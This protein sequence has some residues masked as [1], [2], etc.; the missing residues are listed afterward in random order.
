M[1]IHTE[2]RPRS[3]DTPTK[4]PRSAWFGVLRR[5]FSEFNEDAMTDWAAALT[6]YGILSVFPALIALVSILG[7]I[8]T[9][10]TKPLLDNLGSFAPGPAHQILKNAL[11][12]LTQSRGGAGIL[13]VV[14]L[15]GALWAASGYIGAF[16][17]A[18]NRIWDVEEG[19]PIWR[20]LPLRLFI[21]VLMLILLAVSAFAVVVTGPLADRVGKLVGI[22][23]AAVTAWDIAKWP[24]LILV[25]SFMFSILYYAS[26]NVRHPSFRWLAPGGILAVA[27]WML[28]SAA[29]G[30]YV[31]NF[32]SYNKTYGSLGAIIIFLVW[33]WLSNVAILLGA[34]LNAE[35]A[36]GRQI[37]AGQPADREPFL[38]PRREPK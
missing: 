14:G 38:P 33:L 18:S 5:T 37:E 25:V 11:D 29:F 3:G 4:L 15:A 30:V 16:I 34:E 9:S 17:R 21:T 1:A 28:V 22:G 35:I 27:V 23:G 7:L 32:S 6:Y 13:F 26:P 20:V 19:R 2:E 10:A 12:G 24:V 31:A 8:G 36:R